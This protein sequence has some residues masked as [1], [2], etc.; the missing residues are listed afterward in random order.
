MKIVKNRCVYIWIAAFLLLSCSQFPV[1][2]PAE[3]I[4]QKTAR[5]SITTVE[6]LM[7]YPTRISIEEAQEQVTDGKLLISVELIGAR[8]Y[9][10]GTPIT[11]RIIFH[12]LT[13]QSL[14]LLDEF[15]VS[16]NYAPGEILVYILTPD[17]QPM[18]N[19]YALG[20]INY[21]MNS[22]DVF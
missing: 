11:F 12:N 6:T 16:P 18:L 2:L 22:T 14:W 17:K 3:P 1:L 5:P 19:D 13:T 7:A 15:N 4:S 9:K 8:C 20:G 21:I 10:A